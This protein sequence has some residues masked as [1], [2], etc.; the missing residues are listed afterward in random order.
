M[1]CQQDLITLEIFQKIW[2]Q[3]YE[4]KDQS[5]TGLIIWQ[6]IQICFVRREK[7]AN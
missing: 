3:S 4:E 2:E 6:K 7:E 1:G 5:I